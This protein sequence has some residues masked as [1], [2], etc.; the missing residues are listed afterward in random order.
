[1]DPGF[2]WPQNEINDLCISSHPGGK[3]LPRAVVHCQQS[4]YMT[5]CRR[6]IVNRFHASLMAEKSTSSVTAFEKIFV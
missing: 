4:C 6:G 3:K 1:M 5:C 2:T